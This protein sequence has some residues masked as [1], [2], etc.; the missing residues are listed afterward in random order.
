M[1]MATKQFLL[2][3]F[4]GCFSPLCG[5]PSGGISDACDT[6]LPVHGN[7]RT[8]T[9]TAPYS[10]TVSA[11]K[12]NPGD[13]IKVTIRTDSSSFKGFLLE[14]RSIGGDR[15]LGTFTVTDPNTQGLS[16]SGGPN[17]AISHTSATAKTQVT[18]NWKA[19]IGAGPVR[20]TA[21]VLQ[22]YSIFWSQVQSPTVMSAQIT[23]ITCASQKFCFSDPPDCNPDNNS[24]LFMSSVPS[25]DGFVFEMSGP[26][27]GYLAIGFSDDKYMGNDDIY[28]CTRNSSG[29]I[30]VQQ[31]F[32][33]GRVSPTL[34]NTSSVESAEASYVDGVLKC[35]FITQSSI[36]TQARAST[37][38]SYYIF[39]ANGPSQA[40]GQILEHT[41]IPLITENKVDLSSFASSSAQTGTS[42][43]ILVHGALMLIAWMTTGSIGMI[44]A[45]YLKNVGKQPV[46][47]KAAWFLAHF[48]LMVL[49]VALTLIAFIIIFVEVDGWSSDTGAHPVLGCILMI[50]SFLQPFAALFRPDPKSER[51]FIFNW[52]HSLNAFVIKIL[53]VATIFLGLQLI[54]T[55]PNQWMAKVM[56]GFVAWEVLF[57]IILEANM[58]LKSKGTYEDLDN[59]MH[60]ESLALFV[61]IFGNLAFLISL[62]VGI[63]GS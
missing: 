59:K 18:A 48:F 45:R 37:A 53:A 38:S 62:L 55:T 13:T 63:R 50:L 23:N 32:S 29:I 8:Q 41:Q 11:D 46:L 3:C 60:S 52:A 51:R 42:P 28:I 24:C 36:S 17:S 54:D 15:I 58:R 14:A 4:A 40:N 16:C 21:T 9:S 27:S 57:Y 33:T 49:T 7:S 56:G 20:F 6:M 25:T 10:I 1:D 5:Y 47:G 44:M 2:I 43:V 31:A 22:S 39:L 30:T 12:F 26:T 61:F 19:P 34:R 35:L